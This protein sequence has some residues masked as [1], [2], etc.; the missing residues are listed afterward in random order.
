ML[1][2]PPLE[3]QTLLGCQY[4]P[5][6]REHTAPVALPRY[7]DRP[8][9][10]FETRAT[11]PPPPFEP[12][13]VPSK[14]SPNRGQDVAHCRGYGSNPP[15]APATSTS[16]PRPPPT[17]RRR[18]PDNRAVLQD[19]P[20]CIPPSKAPS[21]LLRPLTPCKALAPSAPRTG[22]KLLFTIPS[23]ITYDHP[24]IYPEIHCVNC[25]IR[26]VVLRLFW[27]VRPLRYKIGTE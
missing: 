25:L 1:T 24:L 13:S 15:S 27:P 5:A 6:R 8:F 12:L 7:T 18:I 21:P 10:L 14:T 2:E 11:A 22:P 17:P 16:Y 3:P 23:D 4:Q 20:R 19:R 9:G 26:I